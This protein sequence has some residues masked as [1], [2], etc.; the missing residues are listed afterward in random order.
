[1]T[2]AAVI[3]V[4]VLLSF[5]YACSVGETQST[6]SALGTRSIDG[7]STTAFASAAFPPVS[8]INTPYPVAADPLARAYPYPTVPDLVPK[9]VVVVPVSVEPAAPASYIDRYPPA[10]KQAVRYPAAYPLA[11]QVAEPIYPAAKA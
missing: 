7:G 10:P 11:D 9:L 8:V 1:M 4:S 3:S 2:F 5:A 6:E